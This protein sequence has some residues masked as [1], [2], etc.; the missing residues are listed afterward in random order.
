[1]VEKIREALADAPFDAVLLTGERNRRYAAGFHS[2]A[3]ACYISRKNAFFFTD[4]R[5]IEAARAA[6]KGFTV[7]EVGGGLSYSEAVNACIIGEGAKTVAL[8]D[9]TL[10]Y[11][12]YRRWRRSLEAEAVPMEGFLDGLRAVKRPDE[13]ERIVAAQ[14]IA[15]RA[16]GEVLNDIRPGATEKQVAA[17]LTYLM[18]LYGAENMS[19]DP[20]VV[21]GTNSSKPHG[22]PTDKPIEAGDFVTM[23][24]GCIY[25]G[26][27]S[28]MTRTVAVGHCTEEMERVY[29]TVLAA[30]RAGI[31]TARAGISGA[32]VDGAARD[33]ITRAGYGDAFGHGFGHGVGLDIHEA[34][35]ASPSARGPLL[36]GA[37]LTA[38]PGIYLPGKFGVRIE[39]MLL[40][41]QGG[42]RNLTN[43][44]KELLILK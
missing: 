33:I 21:S 39:D 2:T 35:N 24:F 20:I 30:Q 16:L 12:D 32:D 10:T 8:E 7:R 11:A 44:P 9:N 41:E 17:R 5:Y 6:V 34:P 40:I 22:V 15:E 25:E 3:G 4:F 37:I 29:S 19:F 14:R 31:E 1:M 23:D 27:C 28:D 18:L 13:V 42:C 43:A 38:E 26:Y 36:A